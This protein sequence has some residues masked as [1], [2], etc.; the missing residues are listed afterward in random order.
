MPQTPD[1]ILQQYEAPVAEAR[2]AYQAAAAQIQFVQDQLDAIPQPED[3]SPGSPGEAQ[4]LKRKELSARLESVQKMYTSAQEAYTTVLRQR[5]DAVTKVRDEADPA[6][7]AQLDAQAK[8]DTARADQVAAEAKEYTSPESTQARK[9]AAAADVRLKTAQA[10]EAQYNLDLAR[11]TDP[12]KRAQLQAQLDQAKATTARI[13][14]ETAQIGQPAPRTPEQQRADAAAATTAEAQAA[15]APTVASAQATTAQAQATA[16][17]ATANTAA[18][19]A[20]ADL[21]RAQADAATA[22]IALQDAQRKARQ[23]PTDAQAQQALDA[24]QRASDLANQQLEQQIAQA[25]TLNPIAAQQAQATLDSTKAN[26]Q[27]GVLG[28][29]YGRQEQI[30]QIKSL[31][32]S[33]DILPNEADQ[34]IAAMN[35]GTTVFD[36][37]RQ[38]QADRL[39]ARGQTASNL[40]SLAGNFTSTFNSGLGT[41]ADMNKYAQIGSTAGADAFVALLNMA[42]DRLSKYQLPDAQTA[43]YLGS[44]GPAPQSSVGALATAAQNALQPAALPAPAPPPQPS[45]GGE[46]I[47]SG[48]VSNPQP[49]TTGATGA[50]QVV[51][52]IGAPSTPQVSSGTEGAGNPWAGGNTPPPGTTWQNPA[53]SGD[54]LAS[55]AAK[56]TPASI[57]DLANA[58]PGAAQRAGLGHLVGAA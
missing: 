9:D 58:Y 15:N 29:L 12:I 20:S 42:Q 10:D 50:H 38:A 19:R 33:G 16:A 55:T 43:D 35:R 56:S 27:K 36:A 18:D 13:Q 40:N 8:L 3:V 52:N 6:K 24:A 54:Q 2:N 11:E 57:G 51:I 47:G 1:D 26:L 32:A 30:R 14:K 17:Q 45:Y 48:A 5:A 39:N 25:K 44:G 34:M 23:A 22:Q 7:R 31:V 49:P 28:D 41:L 37:Q 21:Q 4:A 46:N 53:M